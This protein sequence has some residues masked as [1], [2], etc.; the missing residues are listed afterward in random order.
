MSNDIVM[1]A[2]LE[3]FV[4][5]EQKEDLLDVVQRFDIEPCSRSK[6]NGVS[7]YR[8]RGKRRATSRRAG[9][10]ARAQQKMQQNLMVLPLVLGQILVS[11]VSLHSAQAL[12]PG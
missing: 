4:T 5:V 3:D 11:F 8:C 7:P 12:Q 1:S 10:A 6:T 9:A 2:N